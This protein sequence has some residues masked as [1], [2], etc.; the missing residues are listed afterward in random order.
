M[1]RAAVPFLQR[2]VLRVIAGAPGAAPRPRP[3][4]R[5]NSVLRATPQSSLAASR[6]TTSTAGPATARIFAVANR[7]ARI[8]CVRSSSQR[9]GRRVDLSGR[10][11]WTAKSRAC[12]RCRPCP[13]R[14]DDVKAI[15]EYIHSVL[16]TAQ[17]QGGPPPGPRPVLNV[18][19]GD[20]AAGKTYFDAKCSSCH[21]ATG[22]L[23]GHR[24]THCR[25]HAVAE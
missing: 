16:A 7:A 21:S 3:T 8:F 2:Q 10:S 5:R 18:L 1:V 12:L 14:M 20:A 23:A 25:S 24:R 11:R 6:S 13:S 22:D 4:F 19:V 17:R 15:A 9:P